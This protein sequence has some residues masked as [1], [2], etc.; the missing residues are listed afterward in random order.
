MALHAVSKHKKNIEKVA[1]DD[2][3]TFVIKVNF[4]KHIIE[5]FLKLKAYFSNFLCNISK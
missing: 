5:N 1:D 3:K 4:T 2:M